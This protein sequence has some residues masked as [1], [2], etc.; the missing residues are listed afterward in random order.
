M[1]IMFQKFWSLRFE[2]F[3]YFITGISAFILDIGTLFLLKEYANFSAVLSVIINQILMV[4]YV[5]FINKYWSFKAKGVTHK[6]M[7]RFFIL[8]LFNYFFSIF[9]MWLFNHKLGVYYI[10]TR[11]MNVLLAVAWNFLLYKFWV[12]KIKIHHGDNVTV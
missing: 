8:A 1:N 12:Y 6:Q 2:F 3:R 5:F 11:I 10:Y 9:W 4:N 7:I